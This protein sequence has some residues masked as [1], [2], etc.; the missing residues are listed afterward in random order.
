[1]TQ[2]SYRG[3]VGPRRRRYTCQPRG[4]ACGIARRK[5]GNYGNA[6]LALFA[7]ARSS[8]DCVIFDVGQLEVLE[9]VANLP[10]QGCVW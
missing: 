6:V 1:M 7:A 4:N 3:G 5:D 10:A 8:Q 9:L 2:D